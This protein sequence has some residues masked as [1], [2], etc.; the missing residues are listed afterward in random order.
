LKKENKIPS[1]HRKIGENLLEHD[2]P[3]EKPI[4]QINNRPRDT[5][6]VG[7]FKI[8]SVGKKE[9]DGRLQ[10]G[11]LIRIPLVEL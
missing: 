7:A 6:H 8:R 11:H 2:P 10:F 5:S 1:V 9:M 4:S 3:N